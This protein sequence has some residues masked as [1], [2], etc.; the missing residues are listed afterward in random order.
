M[1]I[2]STLSRHTDKSMSYI[3]SQRGLLIIGNGFD[4]DLQRKITYE[5]FYNSDFWPRGEI[6]QCPLSKFLEEKL[7]KEYWYNLE[8][9]IS[10][11]VDV[12]NN[13][14]EYKIKE[15]IKFYVQLVKG[16]QQYASLSSH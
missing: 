13:V 8:D 15:D 11:Y 10:C 14:H 16:M 1:A 3:K 6:S 7:P 5:E 9:A 12:N 2:L 4:C